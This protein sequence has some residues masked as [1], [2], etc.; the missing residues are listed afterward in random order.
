LERCWDFA[1]Q[2]PDKAAQFPRYRDDRNLAADTSLHQ[3]PKTTMKPDLR[4]P[5]QLFDAL[6][7]MLLAFAEL[8]TDLGRQGIML[9]TFD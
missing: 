6:R 2:C 3:H 4:F 5:A 8:F 9:R 7:L 1:P